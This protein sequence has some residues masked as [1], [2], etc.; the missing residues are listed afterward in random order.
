MAKH[1]HE[2]EHEKPKHEMPPHMMH[3]RRARGGANEFVEGDR[4]KPHEETEDLAKDGEEEAR[5]KGG[6]VEAKKPGRQ[7]HHARKRGGH[8]PGMK[9]ADRPD[10][11]KRAGGGATSDE[12]PMTSAGNMSAM[13]YERKDA[14]NDMNTGDGPDSKG[15]LRRV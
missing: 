6:K 11:K 1:E 14:E 9:A 5:K 13:P 4:Q 12:H 10:R 2:H 8:V 3:K 15:G 7:H